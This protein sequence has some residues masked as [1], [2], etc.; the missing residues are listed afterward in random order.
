METAFCVLSEVDVDVDVAFIST[1]AKL[2]DGIYTIFSFEYYVFATRAASHI[3]GG[4]ALVYRDF[5]IGKSY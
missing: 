4:G 1:E 3:K 2:T 5:P